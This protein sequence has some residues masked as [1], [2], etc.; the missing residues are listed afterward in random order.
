MRR[1]WLI[2]E[3]ALA[4]IH[5]YQANFHVFIRVLGT[6]GLM[7]CLGATGRRCSGFGFEAHGVTTSLA[8]S[9]ANDALIFKL[10]YQSLLSGRKGNYQ[11]HKLIASVGA[12]FLD[13]QPQRRLRDRSFRASCSGIFV[14]LLCEPN[15]SGICWFA[16]TAL[17]IMLG[18]S[19]AKHV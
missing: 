11:S 7:M 9:R 6:R 15:M 8:P 16:I 3:P 18:P 13:I 2:Q 14:A 10:R 1:K 19:I 4:T 12:T 17:S 5:L